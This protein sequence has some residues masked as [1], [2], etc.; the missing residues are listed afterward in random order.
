M[1]DTQTAGADRGPTPIAD[2]LDPLTHVEVTWEPKRIEN[3]IRFGRST[4]VQLLDRRRRIVSFQPDRIFAF[5]RWAGNEYGT[6]ASRI[7]IVRAVHP[8]EALQTLPFVRPGGEILLRVAGWPKVERVLQ[9]I[10]AISAAGID[11]CDVLADHW[12]HVANRIA[13][14][15]EPRLYTIARHCAWLKRRACE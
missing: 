2:A 12:R 5:V 7:D 11:P 9:H 13:T 6:V 3:R 14:G 1:T 15:Q 10:D 4:R 8:G